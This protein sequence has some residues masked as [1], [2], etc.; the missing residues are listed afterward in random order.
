MFKRICLRDE[1]IIDGDKTLHLKRGEEYITTSERD[2]KVRVCSSYWAWVPAEWFG[3]AITFASQDK[4]SKSEKAIDK[5]DEMQKAF[6]EMESLGWEIDQP[7]GVRYVK[8]SETLIKKF[9]DEIQVILI[10][11]K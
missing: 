9:I 3:G 2:G 1:T 7:E 8:V 11:D 5:L 6:S 4:K 10:L